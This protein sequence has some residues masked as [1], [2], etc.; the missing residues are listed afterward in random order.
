MDMSQFIR[1]SEFEWEIPPTGNM[2]VP[3]II[4]ASEQLVSQMDQKVLEQ[5]TNVATLP[6]IQKGS[7]AM[8]DAHWG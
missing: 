1:K 5:T 8:P 7:F 6:G 2:R 3:G 4:F